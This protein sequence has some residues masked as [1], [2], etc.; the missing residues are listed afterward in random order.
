LK[1][2]AAERKM[3]FLGLLVKIE[4]ISEVGLVP[5]GILS[6]AAVLSQP[7]IQLQ[8]ERSSEHPQLDFNK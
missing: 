2:E 7:F 8:N 1:I 5:I 4:W 3:Q 6:G